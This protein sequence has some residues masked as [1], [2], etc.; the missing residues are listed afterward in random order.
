MRA[1]RR[2]RD[3]IKRVAD[4]AA[5]GGQL[6]RFAQHRE[7]G[8]GLEDLRVSGC[9]HDRD[10]RI[11][12]GDLAPERQAVDVAR[13]HDIAEHKTHV[14]P[15]RKNIERG[16]GRLHRYGA[17]AELF[18]QRHRN[19]PD[20]RIVLHHQHRLVADG[21]ILRRVLRRA[22]GDGRAAARKID[23][24]FRAAADFARDLHRCRPTAG[25]SRRLG[26]S[27][28]RSPCPDLWW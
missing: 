23:R 24:H 12:F 14:V 16:G 8:L 21:P 17:I 9:Q 1:G 6:I 13:Q 15:R 27:R 2:A 7:F 19:V 22:G 4:D 10:M 28:G 3:G 25:Q 26:S 18:E 11:P 20:V 5:Q